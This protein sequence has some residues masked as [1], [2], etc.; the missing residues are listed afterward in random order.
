MINTLHPELMAGPKLYLHWLSFHGKMP[1]TMTSTITYLCY[2]TKK[3]RYYYCYD[4]FSLP[5][6]G[7]SM[8]N[9]NTNPKLYLHW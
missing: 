8:N 2:P 3:L 9:N 7:K 4:I 6:P 1:V 5:Q